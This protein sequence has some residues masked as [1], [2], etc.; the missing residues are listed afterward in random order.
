MDAI[1]MS[2]M[3][4]FFAFFLHEYNP[5][6]SPPNP[7]DHYPPNPR[8][9][10]PTLKICDPSLVHIQI[11]KSLVN[12]LGLRK[13]DRQTESIENVSKASVIKN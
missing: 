2:T 12:N 7:W 10:P 6:K 5:A 8:D 11:D 9:Y 13:T 1:K 3:L 4:L